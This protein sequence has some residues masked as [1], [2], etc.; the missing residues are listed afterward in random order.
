LAFEFRVAALPEGGELADL[1]GVFAGQVV[2]LR[3]IAGEI[4]KF[5]WTV[6]DCDE[7]P[8]PDADRPVSD[9]LEEEE[10]APDRDIRPERGL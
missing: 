9:V 6:L 2:R 10:V 7:L 1:L 3:T 8:I 5:P 4:V